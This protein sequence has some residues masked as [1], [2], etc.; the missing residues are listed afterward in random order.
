MSVC[1]LHAVA[2]CAFTRGTSQ[3]IIRALYRRGYLWIIEWFLKYSPCFPRLIQPC[4]KLAGVRGIKMWCLFLVIVPA[5]YLLYP[6]KHS[7]QAGII[8][9]SPCQLVRHLRWA[10]SLLTAAGQL[11]RHLRWAIS[12]LTADGQLVRHLRWA[13]SWLTAAGQLVRH[14]RWAISLLTAAGQLVRHL[15]WAISL[16]TAAGQLVRHWRWAVSLL[17]AAGQL[18]RHW[19]WAVS[20]LTA[21]SLLVRHWRWAV[22][23]YQNQSHG[24][25]PQWKQDV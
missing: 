18:V 11:V 25:N 20:L 9:E 8:Y 7:L 16:L 24:F 21:A 10:I 14:L 23:C 19:R 2:H 15:R 4:Q 3:A 17:T 1:I 12:L 22:S 6:S 5:R 13:I